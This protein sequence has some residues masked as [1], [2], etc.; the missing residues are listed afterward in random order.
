MAIAAD[1]KSIFSYILSNN[2]L[3]DDLIKN[4]QDEE[5]C[6]RNFASGK[7]PLFLFND[8]S[9][10]H[11]DIRKYGTPQSRYYDPDNFI[12]KYA[13]AEYFFTSQLFE[14]QRKH[15][16]SWF[17]NIFGIDANEFVRKFEIDLKEGLRDYIERGFRKNVLE[18]DD[19]YLE[20]AREVFKKFKDFGPSEIPSFYNAILQ[21]FNDFDGTYKNFLPTLEEFS[22]EYQIV[23]LI[24]ILIA[25]FDY[26]GYNK[27]IWN[28]NKDNRV[29]AKASVRQNDWL[30]T[31]LQYKESGNDISKIKDGSVKNA[32]VYI[33]DP[34]NGLPLLSEKQREMFS[35]NVLHQQVFIS[36]HFVKDLLDYFKEVDVP[37][38]CK[39]NR[40]GYISSFLYDEGIKPNWFDLESKI[41]Y[42]LLGASWDGEDQ[43]QRFIKNSI[44]ENGYSPDSG[45]SSIEVAKKINSGDF[46]ALKSS[47]T[48][49][50]DEG[51]R[52]PCIR[53]KAIG[54]VLS[55]AGDGV[56][57]SVKWVS[58]DSFDVDGLSYR[59]TVGKVRSNDKEA[60]FDF[61]IDEGGIE[62][63]EISTNKNFIFY[64]PPGTGK[65]FKLINEI[66]KKFDDQKPSPIANLIAET[67][68][69]MSWWRVF[70]C[71][72]I[73]AD[74]PVSVSEIQ[75]HEFVKV[76]IKAS[77][78]NTVRQTIWGT[79]QAR[80]ILESKTVNSKDRRTPYVFNKSEKSDWFL[81]G[82]WKEELLDEIE[83]VEKVRGKREIVNT[84]KRFAFVTFHPS[85][86][87]ED[88]VEGIKPVLDDEEESN[89]QY[90]LVNG[91]FKRM[92]LK[93][94]EDPDNDYAIF[95]DEINRGNIPAIFGELITL[96]EED[97][98]EI[99]STIL[100]YSKKAF[101][102]PRNLFIY[103]TMN[104]AD[105]SVEALDVALRRRF[106][107]EEFEP[108]IELIDCK[109][110]NDVVKKIVT[111]I[112]QRIEILLGKDYR[113]GHSYFMNGS[114]DSLEGLKTVF[115]NKVIPLLN[116]Y[117]YEDWEKLCLVL[118]KNFVE[119][120]NSSR[121][122][123]SKSYEDTYED[124]EDKNIYKISDP[125]DW[126]LD[127]FQSIYEE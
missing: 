44:W 117:F 36:D 105:R 30:K 125:K 82:D 89:V 87:Y 96:I 43:V 45:D 40:T 114:V 73:D 25:H 126:D 17:N 6:S 52:I 93:A 99:V 2:L 81:A 26:H 37:V 77:E 71:A 4:L 106:L 32:L 62:I 123:F 115:L 100:P 122:K 9:K 54:E 47:F 70:A 16:Y 39:E 85:Y 57:L 51:K 101:T 35:K 119:K 8:K 98:R 111:A 69:E 97:K 92:C 112:N 19:F 38:M 108:E 66:T 24:G 31:L 50:N 49:N 75:S 127:T 58:T 113:I 3:N 65:T 90:K 56:H 94:S 107:F 22:K 18:L 121:V 33:E 103:G 48:K 41:S 79:L 83:L 46:I 53:I 20:K 78:S 13:D 110:N 15:Y 28:Q 88:F 74:R 68:S 104:T 109:Y 86:S 76:K 14:E 118:G 124:F 120:A 91:I 80:S 21:N 84:S 12:I 67:F 11:K 64:G 59:K 34:N 5:Y 116:E 95:I 55:N 29:I 27:K 23:E 42:W 63:V 10:A 1:I 60:I 72:L 102:V 7:F 61:E